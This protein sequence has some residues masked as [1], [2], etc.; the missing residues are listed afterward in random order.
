MMV[1]KRAGI[2]WKGGRIS[3]RRTDIFS[4]PVN[5]KTNKRRMTPDMT[6]RTL[7]RFNDDIPYSNSRLFIG[8]VKGSSIFKR[9]LKILYPDQITE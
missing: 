2:N 8:T 5:K 7:I 6:M 3:D 1:L 4:T 9:G